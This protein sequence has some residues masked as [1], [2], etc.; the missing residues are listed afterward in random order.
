[1]D[2]DLIKTLENA[3]AK[4]NQDFVISNLKFLGYT[5]DEINGAVSSFKKKREDSSASGFPSEEEYFALDISENKP[6]GS[7]VKLFNAIARGNMTPSEIEKDPEYYNG[8]YNIYRAYSNDPAVQQLPDALF[9][10]AGEVDPAAFGRLKRDA[11]R[12]VQYQIEKDRKDFQ[13][14]EGKIKERQESYVSVVSPIINGAESIL[15]GVVKFVGEAS[16]FEPASELGDYLLEDVELSSIAGMRNSGLTDEQ[17]SKGFLQNMADGDIGAGLSI[18]G[19]QLLQQ[20]PQLALI[21]ATGGAAG[22]TTLGVSSAGSALKEVED[23]T[24]MTSQEKMLYG[25]GSGIVEGLSERLFAGDIRALRR[26]LGKSDIRQL[27]TNEFKDKLFSAVPAGVRSTLEEGFEEAVASAAQQTILNFMTGDPI[28]PIEITEGAIIGSIMGGGTYLASRGINAVVEPETEKKKRKL[29][30]EIKNLKEK[31]E[32]PNIPQDQ[33]GIVKEKR[34][35]LQN[36]LGDLYNTTDEVVKYMSEKNVEDFKKFRGLQLEIKRA[37]NE[38]RT[39]EDE[40]ISN[41]QKEKLQKLY[42]QASEI[43]NKYASEKEAGVPSPVKEGAPVVQPEPVEVPSPEAPTPS[44]VLQAPEKEVRPQIVK[45]EGEDLILRHGSPY[46][47]D[48]F[49][50]ENVGTGEGRQAFGYGLYFTESSDIAKSYAKKLSEDKTGLLYT[51]KIKGGKT[52]N[53]LPWRE[54]VTDGYFD[55]VQLTPEE[56][57]QYQEYLGKD[58]E[59]Y[60]P[61]FEAF[62]DAS[63]GSEY[64]VQGSVEAEKVPN[65]A[66]YADLADAFGKQKATEILQR[67]GYSGIVYDSKGGAGD[68]RNF[69][70][71]DPAA[72]EIVE[73][74][75]AKKAP[76]E[77][78][79]E[80]VTPPKREPADVLSDVSSEA[81]RYRDERSKLTLDDDLSKKGTE[82]KSS[83]IDG[84]VAKFNPGETVS[85]SYVIPK[86]KAGTAR[87]KKMDVRLEFYEKD[88]RTEFKAYINGAPRGSSDTER[89]RKGTYNSRFADAIGWP[90]SMVGISETSVE[91]SGVKAPQEVAP[92]A[93]AA[94]AKS[95]AEAVEAIKSID[96]VR[97]INENPIKVDDLAAELNEIL[98]LVDQAKEATQAT[99]K[100]LRSQAVIRMSNLLKQTDYITVTVP[101]LTK[102]GKVAKSGKAN[103]EFLK[104]DTFFKDFSDESINSNGT[105]NSISV[106]N[107][108]NKLKKITDSLDFYEGTGA[109]IFKGDEFFSVKKAPKKEEAAKAE[110][111]TKKEEPAV[112]YLG[113]AYTTKKGETH[114]VEGQFTAPDG[115]VT[116]KVRI[117]PV[118][119][120]LGKRK[121]IDLTANEL[122]EKITSGEY[123]ERAARIPIVINGGYTAE[124][125]ADTAKGLGFGKDDVYV[126]VDTGVTKRTKERTIRLK[127]ITKNIGTEF[128]END[129]YKYFNPT[130]QQ[131]EFNTKTLN[132]EPKKDKSE[133]VDWVKYNQEG[134][135]AISVAD[136]KRLFP[137]AANV[138]LANGK[139]ISQYND[140]TLLSSKD[141]R[142]LIAKGNKFSYKDKAS[143][144]DVTA[145]LIDLEKIN[146]VLSPL[147]KRTFAA[148]KKEVIDKINSSRSYSKEQKEILT[149]LIGTIKGDVLFN[150]LRPSETALGLGGTSNFYNFGKNVLKA[151]NT[152]SLVH[153]IGHWGFYNILSPE[154][155]I[156]FLRYARDRFKEDVNGERQLAETISSYRSE[157]GLGS[158]TH[159]NANENYQEYFATQFTQW[160]YNEQYT[161]GEI[162]TLFEKILDFVKD[163]LKVLVDKKYNPDLVKYFEK[164]VQ[165]KEAEIAGEVIDEDDVQEFADEKDS[166]GDTNVK[167]NGKKSFIQR[168][169]SSIVNQAWTK[170][171]RVVR[172]FKTNMTSQVNNERRKIINQ[173]KRLDALLKNADPETLELTRLLMTDG[174]TDSQL[175]ALARKPNG[176]AIITQA[177]AMR[178]YIDSFSEDFISN[179]AFYRLSPELALTIINNMGSYMRNSYRFWKDDRYEPSERA[180]SE[181]VAYEFQVLQQMRGAQIAKLFEIE[182]TREELSEASIDLSIINDRIRLIED[183]VRSGE[184]SQADA[185]KEL[186]RLRDEQKEIEDKV[187]SLTK[188]SENQSALFSE[189]MGDVPMDSGNIAKYQAQQQDY[190]EKILSEEGEEIKKKA[191]ESIQLYLDEIQKIRSGERFKKLGEISPSSIKLPSQEFRQ[192]KSLPDT[193]KNVLGKET[194]P[195]IVFSD[196]A[197]ALSSIKYKGHMLYA[198]SQSLGG[199]EKYIKNEATEAEKVSGEFRM[200]TD[201]FSPLN[202]RYVHKDIF[203]AL[204]DPRIYEG[205]QWWSD[206]YF[207]TLLAARKS[208]VIYNVP[209]WRKN[210]T[211]GWYTIMAN[212]VVNASFIS[213]MQNRAKL[214]IKGEVDPETE[215]LIDLAAKYGLMGQS[216]N[217]N[218]MGFIDVMYSR[219][220]ND[221]DYRNA[222]EKVS[223]AIAGFDQKVGGLYA[224][225]DDYTKLIVFRSELDS[226]AG[227]LYG[228]KFDELTKAEKEKA[229]FEAAE[230]VK[231]TTPTFSKLPKWYSKIAVLPLGDFVS[232]ELEALRSFGMNIYEGNKDIVKALKDKSLSKEQKAAYIKAGTARLMGSAAIAGLRLSIVAALASA[233][234]GDDDELIDDI[235]AARPNWMEG[236][237]IIPVKIS[238]DG[239][240][241]VYDYS[242]EDPYGSFFDL[243]RDPGSF[244][245]YVTDLLSLNMGVTFLTRLA[246]NKDVYGRDIVESYDNLQTKAYKYT[247]HTLKSLII[248]PFVSSAYRDERRRAEAEADQYD[249]LDALARFASRAIIRDYQYNV[250]TQFYYFSDQFRTKGKVQYID[251]E[252]SARENRL[253]E[254]TEVKKMYDAIANIAI[255]K[256]NM[257]LLYDA[258]QSVKRKFK[259][260]EE[261]YILSG[262]EVPEE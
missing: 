126:I 237:S 61:H 70:V 15:G 155:R 255:Q 212:G 243:V 47:F 215:Q 258:R 111:A 42:T 181:A 84:V 29:N 152:P 69:V 48:Q 72:I 118:T 76:A 103:L 90:L 122:A 231:E 141:V 91:L 226:Q 130:G 17:I 252:G 248:P 172:M 170:D 119:P 30:E 191:E 121:I 44:G 211:G 235:G 132:Y 178:A 21:A 207:K 99:A 56:Q 50:L 20:V 144:D 34:E 188:L 6:R 224:S 182:R 205:N 167:F 9:T 232:F 77:K 208:K 52:G 229:A 190:T 14:R 202:G 46:E 234:L 108:L 213:D 1:M 236:H 218:L 201:R 139:K 147:D 129:F 148:S 187:I 192:R 62:K 180:I 146:A 253:A 49:L 85:F 106:A 160:M 40:D 149:S 131:Y 137:N 251:L 154:D 112:S 28:D 233:A 80:A 105:I 184:M 58:R 78:A 110:E 95:I 142:N 26:A 151:K 31:E 136:V 36:E 13:E 166:K 165:R 2:E 64:F 107:F 96:D 240:A 225:V 173:S 241:T 162:K 10:E 227:K 153:E 133:P 4:G 123:T 113:K 203:E 25:V 163:Y 161:V 177:S 7:S 220:N 214:M 261:A 199:D 174:I 83:F 3:Y 115:T 87:D 100:K 206:I 75:G 134:F 19:P 249:R 262:Y 246:E 33:K 116:Y 159:S 125:P 145:K 82:L 143:I 53:W 175:D 92:K 210:L 102:A 254:L 197:N 189:L 183:E 247:E 228:K 5:D 45:E 120:A 223:D 23:R 54:P 63:E 65:S 32:D 81:K 256:E 239:I 93:G 156:E 217:A 195:I 230:L 35:A 59:D 86:G 238:K 204:V 101:V 157:K 127:N 259:A 198:I 186:E 73:V 37:M 71:F 138:V 38:F 109:T 88:G 104:Y 16:G 250:G 97:K 168:A 43:Y 24:D 22:I 79:P 57:A 11:Y 242:M 8:L 68:A 179:P 219:A 196:T 194:D 66:V 18:L 176:K 74:A 39:I 51:V 169:V 193:I 216:V 209:T 128:S 135:P 41:I 150:F 260:A 12:N 60:P 124:L 114:L 171:Q 221:G 244:P 140:T 222:Y 67:S 27:T 98:S 89:T 158:I 185:K 200:V 257:K 164:I 245:E 117:D 55:K 94:P